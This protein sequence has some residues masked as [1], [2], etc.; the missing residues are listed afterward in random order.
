MECGRAGAISG[1][2]GGESTS[3]NTKY[4]HVPRHRVF[5]GAARDDP[6][7]VIR[8]VYER[9]VLAIHHFAE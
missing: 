7:T 5:I 4:I 8:C 9:I 3:E 2:G 1:R 6:F